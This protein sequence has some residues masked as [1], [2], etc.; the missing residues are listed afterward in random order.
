M[1]CQVPKLSELHL[2]PLES[3]INEASYF[4]SMDENL[5]GIDLFEMS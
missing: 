1:M 4:L 3:Q 5:K 2:K